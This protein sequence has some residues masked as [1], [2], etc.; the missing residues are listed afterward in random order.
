KYWQIEN[1][2]YLDF[3]ICPKPDP[4]RVNEEIQIVKSLDPRP[5]LLTDS[6]ELSTWYPVMELGDVFGTT[7]YRNVWS[8]WFGIVE[9]PLP[10]MFYT[11][12][13]RIVQ[14]ITG[15]NKPSIVAELQAEPW[16][17]EK[18]SLGQI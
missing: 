9:Y 5:V 7:L 2:P 6:G 16:P 1:E 10:P 4:N 11:A 15:M 18:K 13:S 8:P 17:A 12:K 14:L 3:G